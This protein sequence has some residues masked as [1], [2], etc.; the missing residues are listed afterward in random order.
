MPIGGRAPPAIAVAALESTRD[1]SDAILLVLPL[2]QGINHEQTLQQVA[3]QALAAASAGKLITFASSPP[4]PKGYG[5]IE[6]AAGAE[7]RG[8][9]NKPS[10]IPAS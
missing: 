8:L 1:G 6:A 5:C 10:L 4:L 2:D 7:I 3:R 9:G